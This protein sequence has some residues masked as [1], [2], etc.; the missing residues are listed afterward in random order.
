MV[1]ERPTILESWSGKKLG[2]FQVGSA[3]AARSGWR[4]H[5]RRS[6]TAVQDAGREQ[7]RARRL[8]SDAF[9]HEGAQTS[10]VDGS[11][12]KRSTVPGREGEEHVST[13]SF[14]V[15]GAARVQKQLRDQGRARR[16]ESDEFA[17]NGAQTINVGGVERRQYRGARQLASRLG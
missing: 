2:F 11:V 6:A 16:V 10:N 13:V 9:G 5:G 1:T 17:H 14:A 15:R 4:P 3:R 7:G 12:V 8:G